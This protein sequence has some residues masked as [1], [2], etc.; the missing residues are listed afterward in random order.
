MSIETIFISAIISSLQFLIIFLLNRVWMQLDENTKAIT[1]IRE[2]LP[3]EYVA[4]EEWRELRK[5]FHDTVE[6]VT[7]LRVKSGE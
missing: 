6:I 1:K 7:K 2:M 5:R 4:K 3:S